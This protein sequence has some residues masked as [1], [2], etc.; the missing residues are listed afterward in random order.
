ML[1]TLSGPTHPPSSGGKPR[2]LVILLHGVGADGNDLIGLAPQW[3]P[4]LPDAEFLAPNAPFPC[5]MAPSGF[6]WFSLQAREPTMILGGVRAGAPMLDAFIDEALAARGLGP[7]DLALVGFSQGTIMALY[8]G[9]RRAQPVA[10]ILGY[11]GALVGP[12]V[13]A[14]EIR[15][16]PRVL[17]VHGT[18]D[19]IVPY[20]ALELAEATLKSAGV[21]VETVSRPGL[22]HG[23]D[24]EGLEHGARF[25][26]EVLGE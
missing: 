26:G 7:K 15:S 19:Q 5:D 24:E 23:I 18:A 8:V 17:L 6:Q 21:P 1:P 9:L 11:S 14:R 4:L 2:R 22:A 12:D 25:L 13:L 16:R 20:Q 10:G 3:A